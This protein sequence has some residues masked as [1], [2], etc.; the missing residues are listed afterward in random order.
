[1]MPFCDCSSGGLQFRVMDSDVVV[2]EI[3]FSGG[4]LG[5]A[6]CESAKGEYFDET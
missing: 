1:M 5:A 3:K 6:K 4:M 2:S